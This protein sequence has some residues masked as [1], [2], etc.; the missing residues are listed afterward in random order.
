MDIGSGWPWAAAL[1]LAAPI[2]RELIGWL[3]AYHRGRHLERLLAAARP[4]TRITEVDPHGSLRLT[5][6]EPAGPAGEVE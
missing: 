2:C 5:V 3:R 4:G 1:L 6:G